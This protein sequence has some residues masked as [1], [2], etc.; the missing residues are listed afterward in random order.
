[1][2]QEFPIL[3]Y[4]L[5]Q[6]DP[7]S[8]PPLPQVIYQNLITQFPQLN[9]PKVI[10]SLTQSIPSTIIQSLFL[11]KALGP[12]PDP[13]AVSTARIKIQE[14][15]ETGKE[16]EIYKAVVRMEE[17]HN[18][19]E[20]QLREVEERL[21]GVYK[22][23]VGEFEDVKVN[24]EVVSILKQVESG[25]VVERVDL[26]GRQLKLLPEAFGKLHGLVLLNL[27]RNQLE[28][29]PDSIAGLQKLE[30]LDVSSNLLLS[31][32]DSIGLLRTLKVLNVSGNKLNYLPESIALCS[33]LVELDASFNNL[34]SLP[35]NIGYGLTNL[36]RLSIQLNKI[37][38][39]PP[40]IC[41]MK[42]LRYLDVH[43]NELHGLPY[44]IGRLTNLEVLDLSSNFSDLTELPE[45][46]GDLANLRE[47][48]LSNNQIRA[49]PDTFGRLENLA[50][51]I[52]DENPLVIP[53]K[54]IVNKGVQ[55]VREFMQKRWL[56]MIAEE[57]QRRMLEVNQQQS[58]TGWLAWGNSLL[59]NFVSGVSQSVSG[60]I[61]GT[62]PP[63]DPY[64]DQQL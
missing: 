61:G 64:L 29:L 49:L 47:L 27:S 52:L 32:P 15:G 20:R 37:H 57:Q 10:S 38:I 5:S 4:L 40:S 43:F 50:N 41:E 33:S 16:V 8:H 63:Q 55:A 25:S 53:P 48:N 31:L 12:R 42:S 54:E 51:L 17:M 58:Q 1:M 30:E 13:D 45:T 3:S 36:E 34:V 59:N 9:N 46:V 44:A 60:Y 21:S 26:S 11:L 2:D 35:T 6:L 14:L 18:E 19:Y 39:L 56:D 23:V 7:N 22:N 24:E 28:V 62:K